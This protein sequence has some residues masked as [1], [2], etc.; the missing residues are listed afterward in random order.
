MGRAVYKKDVS[1]Y[2]YLDLCSMHKEAECDY[3]GVDPNWE[4]FDNEHWLDHD[5]IEK[6][7]ADVVRA[8]LE[9]HGV[10]VRSVKFTITEDMDDS[11]DI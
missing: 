5:A 4:K 1:G 8:T 7:V 3:L 10:E 2:L 6:D 11:W 9:K